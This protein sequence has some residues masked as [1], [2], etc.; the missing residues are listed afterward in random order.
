MNYK[1]NLIRCCFVAGT[2]EMLSVNIEGES[3]LNDGVAILLYEIFQGE[4]FSLNL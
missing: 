2:S 1:L 4:L 3:L